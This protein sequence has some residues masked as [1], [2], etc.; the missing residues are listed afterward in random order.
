MAGTTSRQGKVHPL[1]TGFSLVG[2]ETVQ[3]NRVPGLNGSILATAGEPGHGVAAFGQARV[4]RGQAVQSR[5]S[6]LCPR[7]SI[8]GSHALCL[9]ALDPCPL[10]LLLNLNSAA[11]VGTCFL[12]G[13]F[14]NR[15]LAAGPTEQ[16]S[17]TQVLE[18]RELEAMKAVAQ[19]Q[20]G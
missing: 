5:L 11:S 10:M 1:E 7:V 4:T 8:T 20:S 15:G 9:L 6:Q 17:E 19:R 13:R 2:R 16:G 18:E 14:G 3:K 12:L